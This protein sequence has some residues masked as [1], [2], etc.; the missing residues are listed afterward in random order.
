[1]VSRLNFQQ[2]PVDWG[3]KKK[4]KHSKYSSHSWRFQTFTI[5]L[6]WCASKGNSNFYLQWSDPH[7]NGWLQG[8]SGRLEFPDTFSLFLIRIYRYYFVMEEGRALAPFTVTVTPCDVPIEWSILVHK[9]SASFLGKAA[10]GKTFCLPK[11]R[12]RKHKLLIRSCVTGN[13]SQA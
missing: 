13:S 1:M 6:C 9:A 10:R 4:K 7:Q 11:Q 12:Q 3:E 2:I 5:P 8:G